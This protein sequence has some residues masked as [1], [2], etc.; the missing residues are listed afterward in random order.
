MADTT[1]FALDTRRDSLER[2]ARAVARGRQ[3]RDLVIEE[4]GHVVLQEVP[5]VLDD[6]LGGASVDVLE[7]A[8]VDAYD[9]AELVREVVLAALTGLERD[10]RAHGDG[11]DRHHCED[12]PLRAHRFRVDAEDRDVII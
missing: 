9:V 2:L 4:C 10:A 3:L 7:Q 1:L 11:R 6:D 8:L 5:Q 12:A